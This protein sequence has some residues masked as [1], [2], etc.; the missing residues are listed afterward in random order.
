M[1]EQHE[2]RKKGREEGEGR[3]TSLPTSFSLFQ[4]IV[5][6]RVRR[7]RGNKGEKKKKKSLSLIIFISSISDGALPTGE[8]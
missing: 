5:R 4:E 2:E 6:A 1:T 3:G 7:R 8:R